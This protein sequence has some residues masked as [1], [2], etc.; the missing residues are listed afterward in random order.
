M[1]ILAP[2]AVSQEVG[3]HELGE[4]I[5]GTVD[6][7]QTELSRYPTTMGAYVLDEIDL[8]M[9]V[10]MRVDEMAQVRTKVVDATTPDKNVG[11]LRMKVR[12]CSA[13]SPRRPRSPTSL[14]RCS[15]S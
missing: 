6:R 13:P 2:A 10:E 11:Q 4:S 14:C 3:L 12:P 5:A 1:E 8:Q 9:P 7:V 15:P